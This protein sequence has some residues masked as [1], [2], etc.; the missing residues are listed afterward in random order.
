MMRQSRE[1][2]FELLVFSSQGSLLVFELLVLFLKPR[3]SGL[4][5]VSLICLNTVTGRTAEEKKNKG[6]MKITKTNKMYE[7]NPN[8]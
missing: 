5:S 3:Q 6:W 1:L 4:H 7:I 2:V 8:I